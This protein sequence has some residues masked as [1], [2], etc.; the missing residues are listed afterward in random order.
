MAEDNNVWNDKNTSDALKF[1]QQEVFTFCYYLSFLLADFVILFTAI[2]QFGMNAKGTRDL[3]ITFGLIIGDKIF[4]IFFLLFKMINGVGTFLDK[5]CW[6]RVFIKFIRTLC[7]C[8]VIAM[9]FLSNNF[10]D[11]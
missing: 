11:E 8:G 4:L 3:T 7:M 9:F 5:N 10:E 2:P 1:L 6:F